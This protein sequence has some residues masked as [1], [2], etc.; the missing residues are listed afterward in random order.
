MAA[1][2]ASTKTSLQ[3]RLSAHARQRWPQLNGVEVRF[4]GTFAYVTARLPDGDSMPLMRLRYGGSAS[5]WGFASYLA[6]KNGYQDSVLP[7]TGH[8]AGSPEDALDTA[9]GLYLGDPTAWT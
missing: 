3:Q 6:S 1:P 7:T 5:R 4:R 9:C 2:P 8:T